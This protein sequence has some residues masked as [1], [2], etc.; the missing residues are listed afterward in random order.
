MSVTTTVTQNTYPLRL[1]FQL[2]DTPG[3]RLT[4]TRHYFPSDRNCECAALT[5]G[6][7][8]WAEALPKLQNV[9]VYESSFQMAA[10]QQLGRLPQ[11]QSLRLSHVHMTREMYDNKVASDF[12]SITE[13]QLENASLNRRCFESLL[14]VAWMQHVTE[15][16]VSSNAF[17]DSHFSV[18]GH[19]HLPA[20]TTLKVNN[21]RLHLQSAQALAQGTF[22]QTL[23]SFSARA[24]YL[25]ADGIRV[26]CAVVCPALQSVDLSNNILDT[27]GLE[28]LWG[29]M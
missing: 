13:L 28:A 22:W 16:D 10:L 23:Q 4:S 21:M 3:F 6:E 15:L 17:Q 18:L 20:L 11:L 12:C 8:R 9:V 24:S 25:K 29:G 1:A 27:S 2:S 5:Q 7:I 19:A 26:L 14:P